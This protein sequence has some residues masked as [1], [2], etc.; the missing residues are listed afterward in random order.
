MLAHSLHGWFTACAR[1]SV[2][3]SSRSCSAAAARVT[4]GWMMQCWRGKV[5]ATH[6]AIHA[7]QEGHVAMV[8][9]TSV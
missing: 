3:A 8:R 1:S 6:S 2:R 4:R 5:K 7:A 9:E